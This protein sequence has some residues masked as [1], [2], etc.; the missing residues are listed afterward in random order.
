[1]ADIALDMGDLMV[2]SEAER[3]KGSFDVSSSGGDGNVMLGYWRMEPRIPKRETCIRLPR[4]QLKTSKRWSIFR[5]PV[6]VRDVDD[7][8]YTPKIVSIGP[9]HHNS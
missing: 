7:K 2:C 1:M 6:H 9:F 5:V 8:D 3:S 4:L